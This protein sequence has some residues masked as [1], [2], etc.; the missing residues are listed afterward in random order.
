MEAKRTTG[1]SVSEGAIT[2]PNR[3]T[4]ASRTGGKRLYSG[5]L[6]HFKDQSGL[7]RAQR[8]TKRRLQ[9][10]APSAGGVEFRQRVAHLQHHLVSV[11]HRRL[12]GRGT[13]KGFGRAGWRGDEQDNLW[14][15]VD[16]AVAPPDEH[17][18]VEVGDCQ[19]NERA[20]RTEDDAEEIVR[21]LGAWKPA[22]GEGRGGGEGVR[23]WEGLRVRG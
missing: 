14:T 2:S 8:L 3:E 18:Q 1:F 21:G 5:R 7:R 10:R 23:R 6:F 9:L 4:R 16:E 13:E 12:P 22:G 17:D 15:V 11:P 20:E 19:R